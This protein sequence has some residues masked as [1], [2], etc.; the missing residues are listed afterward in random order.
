[1][2]PPD[3]WQDIVPYNFTVSPRRQIMQRPGIVLTFFLLIGLIVQGCAGARNGAPQAEVPAEFT[4]GILRSEYRA[5]PVSTYDA[6]WAALNDFNMKITN[7]QRDST[8]GFIQA[9]QPDG[10][11]VNLEMR[12]RDQE[13]TTVTIRV[14]PQGDEELSRAI[15]RRISAHLR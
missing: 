3:G 2:T 13:T 12:T 11:G 6:S 8:G 10:T 9:L 7:S 15:S 4:D 1:M 14:G 5:D